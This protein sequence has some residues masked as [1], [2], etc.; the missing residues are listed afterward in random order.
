MS[1]FGLIAGTH[2]LL[3]GVEDNGDD[4]LRLYLD[5][6][7]RG[8]YALVYDEAAKAEVQRAWASGGHVTVPTPPADCLYSDETDAA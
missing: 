7:H 1:A 6:R 2:V 3:V 5:S 4:A 8:V